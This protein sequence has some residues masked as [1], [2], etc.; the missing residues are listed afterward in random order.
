MSNAVDVAREF[1]NLAKEDGK[2]LTNLQLQKLV[3]I[4]HGIHLAKSGQP[5]LDQE[6]NAWKHGPVIPSVYNVF[7]KY[8]NSP[9][10]YSEGSDVIDLNDYEKESIKD[11][12][13]NFGKFNGWTLREVTHK[14]GSPWYKVWHE[15]GSAKLN[16]IIPNDIIKS[17]YDEIV[18]SGKASVL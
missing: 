16:A 10:E 12:Y 18:R 11:T 14:E 13:V 5:L 1:I 3:Y 6:V 8:K 15:D 17:H 9:I 7:K 2:R 4:A